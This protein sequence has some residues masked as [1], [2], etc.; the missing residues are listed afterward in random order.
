MIFRMGAF[1]LLLHAAV[2]GG[3]AANP[4]GA[5][6]G[7]AQHGGTIALRKRVHVNTLITEPGTM[8]IEWGGAFSM[9][10]N[11]T[12]PSA[13]KYT[14][15]GTHAYWGRTEFSASFDSVSSIVDS[16]YRT[17]Q[18]S[19][20]VGFAATCVVHDGEKL[21][22]AIAPQVGILLRGD[23]GVRVGGTAIARYDVGR[24]S[25]G[26]TFTWTG[27]TAAS[28]TNPAGTID[29]GAGYGFQL[30]PSGPLGHLTPHTN[31]LYEKS[32]GTRRQVSVFEGVEY[33]V[34]DRFAVDFSAQHFGVWG[35]SLDNQV[36][37]GLTVNT[38]RLRAKKSRT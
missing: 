9:G 30:K 35:G 23:D 29:V 37:V 10:G 6:S 18:F 20:R 19:D 24:S 12:F 34:T 21:D 17:T 36:V 13:I 33:Q 11:F 15:E 14:P 31:W 32:T 25:A 8:E 7:S 4:I 26:V 16:G 28:D 38:G 5:G 1:A 27:A 22:L 2:P 3:R